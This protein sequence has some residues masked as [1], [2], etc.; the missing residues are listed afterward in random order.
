MTIRKPAPGQSGESDRLHQIVDAV[1]DFPLTDSASWPK[2]SE[3]SDHT[4]LDGIEV[5]PAGIAIVENRFEGLMNVYVGLEY[6]KDS[7]EALVTSDAFTGRFKGHFSK[8]GKPEI[9]EVTIDTTPFYQ[10]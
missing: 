10:D 6:D 2:L 7:G 8:A 1:Q 4:V 5:D 3:L 9:E